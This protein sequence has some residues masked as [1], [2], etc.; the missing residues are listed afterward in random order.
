MPERFIVRKEFWI[1]K[2]RKRGRRYKMKVG[3]IL[4]VVEHNLP[5][6]VQFKNR[7]LPKYTFTMEEWLFKKHAKGINND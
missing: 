5:D 2:Y 6:Y 4:T 3:D 1:K 7:R